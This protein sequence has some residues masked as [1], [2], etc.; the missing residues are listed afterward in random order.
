MY[1]IGIDLGGTNIV[2]GV[3]DRNYNIIAKAKRKT[4][5]PR[6]ADEIIRDMAQA[7]LEAVESAGLSIDDIELVGVGSPG[8]C[9]PDTGIIE[10]ANN[11]GFENLPM[12]DNLGAILK[13]DVYIENDANAAALGEALAGAAKGAQSCVCITLGTGVG[14]GIIIDGRIYGGFNFAGAE[15]GHTVIVVDGYPCTCGRNG[16][17]ESYASA[18]GLIRQTREAMRNNPG[19]AMWEVAGSLDNVDGR[20]AF[21]AMRKGDPA[22]KEVVDNY[23][24][25]VACGLTNVVN[26]FQP[27]ILCIGGGICK[28]GDTLLIPLEEHIKKERYSKF[29]SHQTRLCVAQLGNDAGVIGAAFLR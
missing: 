26:I 23:I 18:T 24:K 9:N 29:S 6:P 8:T 14:G 11:M 12:R 28:E 2:A 4:R 17:W 21:D 19:S 7:S 13:K 3:V 1:R 20:T 16:C 22:A 5:V 10:Y 15:L 27:E 25:Y